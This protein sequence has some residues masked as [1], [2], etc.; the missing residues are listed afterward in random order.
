MYYFVGGAGDDVFLGQRLQTVCQRLK[1]PIWSNTIWA[2]TVLEATQPLTFKDRRHREQRGK[3]DDNRHDGKYRR[4]D[5]LRL[6][7]QMGH[8]PVVQRDKDLVQRFSHWRSTRV[9]SGTSLQDGRRRR[10]CLRRGPDPGL[11]LDLCFGEPLIDL[12]CSDRMDYMEIVVRLG[13]LRF[14]PQQAV[15]AVVRTQFECSVHFDG[16]ERADFN[17][18]LA[19]H[20]DGDIDVEY[21]RKKLCL[22]KIIRLLVLALFNE[23]AFRRA[24]FF[25]DLAGYTAQT[26]LPVVAVVNKERK[27]ARSFRLGQA[28][29][30]KLNGRQPVL[31]DVTAKEIPG[32]LRQTLYDT[33]TKHVLSPRINQSALPY[34]ANPFYR[35]TSPNTI[36]T[37]PKITIAS[38]TL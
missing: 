9:G 36:S 5:R 31:A 6:N 30:R 17:A 26:I 10:F 27:I 11:S 22:A 4:K 23:D 28:L 32:R 12:S 29:F 15:K 2:I 35:S 3:H 19:A 21:R 25:A 7:R 24:F 14:A 1:Q 38:A 18:D 20:A 34:S 16:V 13:Q 37:V 8:E 33:F